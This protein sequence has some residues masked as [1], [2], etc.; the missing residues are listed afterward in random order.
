MNCKSTARHFL[1]LVLVACCFLTWAS[2]SYAQS[3]PKVAVTLDSSVTDKPVTGRVLL[4]FSKRMPQPMFGPNWFGPEPFFGIDVKELKP[5]GQV[6]FDDSATGLKPISEIRDGEYNVQAILD[7]DF[8]HAEASAGAGNFF[9]KP[10]KV[11]FKG[12]APTA[13]VELKL[14]QVIKAKTYK[15]TELMKFVEIESKLLSDFHKR[16]VK[17]RAMV[18]LPPSYASQPERRFPVYVDITG[19]GGTLS[20]L[21]QRHANG[22]K[23]LSKDDAE[24]IHVYLTGQCKWGHHVYANSATN[25]PRG[26]MLINELIPAIDEQFRTI[27][28]PTARFVGGHSSGGWSSL[29]L[30][31]AYPDFF[32]G[33]WSTAPDPV[34]FRDWQ[35]TNI[36]E[37]NANVYSD[38]KGNK[39]PLARRGERI[40]A[41]YENFTKMDDVLGR[42]GQIRSFEAVFSPLDENQIPKKCW[43]RE[44]GI[45]RSDVVDYWKQYDIS[46]KLKNN[47]AE[48]ESRLKSKIHVY[49]GDTDTFYLEGATILLGERLK[50][51]GSDAVIE[52]FPGKDHMNLLDRNLRARINKE[53]S[54]QFR[55]SHPNDK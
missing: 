47:W 34:D 9:S 8:Y 13:P 30:Q 45:V 7:H 32:G 11:A 31:V 1:I 35:G 25:G 38:P 43:D 6:N 5:G 19:F 16:M 49:M 20:R 2:Q 23:G 50:K 54:E 21:Q 3:S 15:D 22:Q 48:L 10:V 12:G 26:D 51:L 14:D 41:Y 33:V 24:F 52:I 18:V 39:R 29:W 17:E 55:K 36:Y 4:F 40:M 46:L 28:K 44:T 27:A 42:G 37:A 53:M